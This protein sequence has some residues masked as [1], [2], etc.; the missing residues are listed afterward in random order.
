MENNIKQ[1]QIDDIINILKFNRNDCQ[2]CNYICNSERY[3]DWSCNTFEEVLQDA[4]TLVNAG[5]RR[6]NNGQYLCNNF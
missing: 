6:N 4:E 2:K 1:G 5:Y 3:E